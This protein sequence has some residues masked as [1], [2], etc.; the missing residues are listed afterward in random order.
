MHS[1]PDGVLEFCTQ[2]VL[3]DIRA[4][5]DQLRSWLNSTATAGAMP[6]PNPDG[7]NS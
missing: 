3:Q 5:R 6:G 1:Q 4:N 2:N 7:T